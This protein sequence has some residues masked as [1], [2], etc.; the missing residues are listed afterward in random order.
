MLSLAEDFFQYRFVYLAEHQAMCIADLH[1]GKAASFRQMGVPVPSGTTAA[2]LQKL[3]QAIAL[4]KPHTVY[5]LGDFL[6]SHHAQAPDLIAQV[7]EWRDQHAQ[8]N[9]VLVRGNHDSRAG[10]PPPQLNI[11]IVDEP[12]RLGRYA[13]CHHP[14]LVEGAITLAG[15]IHPVMWLTGKGRARLRV[16]CF[17]IQRDC[18]TLPAFGEFTGGYLVKPLSGEKLIPALDMPSHETLR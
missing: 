1:L 7:Q 8:V 5:I 18:I 13:L 14:Q 4:S 17:H 15:H 11:H 3:S 12:Y 16:P 10:D 9:M 2:N 6:H